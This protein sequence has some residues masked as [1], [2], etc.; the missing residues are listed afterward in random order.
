MITSNDVQS[1]MQKCAFL[2]IGN[3]SGMATPIDAKP[4]TSATGSPGLGSRMVGGALKSIVS[5]PMNALMYGSMLYGAGGSVAD[6]YGQ[7]DRDRAAEAELAQ[8]VQRINTL[9]KVNPFLANAPQRKT[10]YQKDMDE[11]GLSEANFRNYERESGKQNAET[12]GKKLTAPTSQASLPLDKRDYTQLGAF[13]RENKTK[14]VPV[15]ERY[16]RG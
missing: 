3:N 15:R 6:A 2:G 9:E 5:N 13:Q 7:Y 10:D 14:T 12:F 4:A 1:F 16:Q 11:Y 8:G